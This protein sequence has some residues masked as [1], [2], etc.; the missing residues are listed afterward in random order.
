[1]VRR[2]RND[3]ASVRLTVPPAL[4]LGMWSALASGGADECI[5]ETRITSVKLFV[6]RMFG[7]VLVVVDS[8]ESVAHDLLPGGPDEQGRAG[9]P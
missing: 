2:S 3:R 5:T 6:R 7:I 8:F 9:H 4:A 1:M